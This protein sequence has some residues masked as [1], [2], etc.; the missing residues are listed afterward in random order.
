MASGTQESYEWIGRVTNGRERAGSSVQSVSSRSLRAKIP[1]EK[2]L[3]DIYPQ[4]ITKLLTYIRFA[5]EEITYGGATFFMH[6]HHRACDTHRTV[7]TTPGV[8]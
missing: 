2:P 3:N 6:K 8:G 4:I 7:T 5:R 1:P